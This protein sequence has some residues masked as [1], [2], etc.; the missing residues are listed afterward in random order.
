MD[1][2]NSTGIYGNSTYAYNGTF[3]GNLSTSNITDGKFGNAL[4]FDG[5]TDYVNLPSVNPTEAISVEAWVKSADS[6]G[7]SGAWQIVSKYSAYILGTGTSAGSNMCFIIFNGTAWV[8]YGNCFTVPDPQNWH[9]FVGTYDSSISQQKLYV[10]GVLRQT[11]TATGTINPD[12][13]SVNIGKRESSTDPVDYFNGSIDEVR[14]WNRVL[15]AEE[16]NASFNSSLYRLERNFTGLADGNYDYYAFAIDAPGNSNQS[17]SRTL[18]VDSV[19]PASFSFASGTEADNANL[20]QDYF[21]VNVTFTESNPDSCLLEVGGSNVSMT[22]SGSN[23]FVNRTSQSDA[24]YA[25]KVYANDSANNWGASASRSVTLDTVN[26]FLSF[27]S[28][29]DSDGGGVGRNYSYVN[30]T[31]TD[32]ANTSAFIDWNKSLVGY[33]AMDWYN[34]TGVFDNSTYGNNGTF[35]GGLET[36]NVT[37]GMFGK[38]LDFDGFNDYVKGDASFNN[39]NTGSLD[40]WVKANEWTD[41]YGANESQQMLTLYNSGIYYQNSAKGIWVYNEYNRTYARFIDGTNSLN[42]AGTVDTSYWLGNW[43]H[44]AVTWNNGVFKFYDDGVLK[45][46]VTNSSLN[47][48]FNVS[49][50]A[51]FRYSAYPF[52]GS[53]DEV[54]V[55]SRVLSAEEINASF[56]NGLYRLNQNFTGLA[57]GNYSYY[58]FAVDYAGNVN[59]SSSRTL[60]VDSGSPSLSFVSPTESDNAFVA[61]DYFAVNAT[62]SD[63]NLG[64]CVVELDGS[65]ITVAPN[66]NDYCLYNATGQS[67]A[68]HT[69]TMYANDSAGNWGGTAQ[70]A[71]TVDTTIPNTIAFVSPT[72]S[73]NSFVS[74][75]YYYVNVT[76]AE[77]NPDS[78]LLQV[79][80]AN[81]SMTRSGSNCYLNRTSQSDGNYSY[82]VYVNDSAGNWN[83]SLN[84]TILLDAAN[85]SLSY[86]SPTESDNAWI[87]RDYFVVNATVSDA[88]PDLC[89]SEVDGSNTS[90]ASTGDSYCTQNLTSQ[91]EG[92]HTY[93]MYLNDSAGNWGGEGQRTVYV[94]T[95][96]PAAFAYVS[97][98]DANNSF[99]NRNYYFVNVTFTELNPGACLLEVGG[100]NVSMTLQGTSYCFVNR[101]GQSDGSYSYRVYLNDSANNWNASFNQTVVLDTSIPQ[102]S[103]VAP[104]PANNSY[105]TAGYAFINASYSETNPASCVLSWNGVNESATVSGGTCNLNKTSLAD[106]NYSFVMYL[107]DSAGLVNASLNRTFTVDAAAPASF[108][109]A[110]GTEADNANLSQD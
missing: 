3:N 28:P 108:S 49:V 13:G 67:D 110:S 47:L 5:D 61:S 34:S 1:W 21:Y 79:G 36:G 11:K 15:T 81:I 58:A 56:N 99:N 80:G 37:N 86:V 23:C 87:S 105:Q 69:Y 83:S 97:P 109:F 101:T 17:S 25:Y 33:W 91:S 75:N 51:G 60:T 26:P 42:I 45:Q 53:I 35:N 9:H 16:V 68:A 48:S 4:K 59:Q 103:V 52:N 89:V 72:D 44:I 106:G 90:I 8:D 96:L 55:W 93:T 19:N 7:Y 92:A 88:N 39:D 50:Y 94:D 2:Y 62:V 43:R 32:G 82:Q 100:S 41:T 14:I 84:Q 6:T 95:V 73:N 57:D 31:V 71:V 63:A 66:G 46:T 12:T 20:S 102:V 77:S 64:L 107:N 22:R 29:T 40:F 18:T 78:C 27:V 85:P 70:R 98:T 24:T 30:V 104:S 76:F 74:R 10:D 65:N 38:A 54:R